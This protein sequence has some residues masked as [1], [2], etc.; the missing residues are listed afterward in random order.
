MILQ[1]SPHHNQTRETFL[2]QSPHARNDYIEDKMKRPY[3]SSLWLSGLLAS[4]CRVSGQPQRSISSMSNTIQEHQSLT[5]LTSPGDS[6]LEDP[7]HIHLMPHSHG[8]S[9]DD[10]QIFNFEFDFGGIPNDNSPDIVRWN[11]LRLNETLKREEVSHNATLIFPANRTFF[12]FHDIHAAELENVVFQIDAHIKLERNQSES[13]YW[14][15][16]ANPDRNHPMALFYFYK[17]QNI[18][19]TSSNGEGWIDGNGPQ[20]WGIPFW[21]YLQITEHRPYLMEFNRATD[22]TISNLLFKDSPLY[23]MR[24]E[25][26]NQ[27]EIHDISIVS[28]RTNSELHTLLDLSA[29]NT[30]GIDVSGHNVWVHDVDIWTQDDCVAVKDNM[31]FEQG[32]I[33][34]NMTFERIR[35]SGTG[36]V[37]GSIGRSEVRNITFRDSYLY[38][39]FKGKS[40]DLFK[41]DNEGEFYFLAHHSL[42]Y[43]YLMC[44]HICLLLFLIGIYM[45]FR[46]TKLDHPEGWMRQEA[47]GGLVCDIVFENIT[48]EA[49]EQWAIWIGPAQQSD[50]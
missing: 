17:G 1:M 37:I 27:V 32:Q 41:L 25:S 28:R 39:S 45:K 6:I 12:F 44:I 15:V 11:T 7:S 22:L 3:R 16:Q 10:H 29:F 24:L 36:F 14:D 23:T 31:S 21:G 40:V 2:T 19:L 35:A 50:S 4:C 33:S 18:T 13:I 38:K 34:S 30:D 9:G 5:L 47:E 8:D 43:T 46:G 49:P 48:M 20:W 42:V 26:V